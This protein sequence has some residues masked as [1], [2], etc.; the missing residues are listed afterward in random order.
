MTVDCL[1]RLYPY[2]E[3][4]RGKYKT[5]LGVIDGIPE[6]IFCNNID[7]DLWSPANYEKSGSSYPIGKMEIVLLSNPNCYMVIENNN[8]GMF[9]CFMDGYVKFTYGDPEKFAITTI[10]DRPG[11]YGDFVEIGYKVVKATQVTVPQKP[12]SISYRKQD[13]LIYTSGLRLQPEFDLTRCD[14]LSLGFK[15]YKDAALQKKHGIIYYDGGVEFS[16]I[17]DINNKKALALE[18]R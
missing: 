4:Q 8:L 11:F 2:G 16:T 5:T 1:Y 13:G 14:S 7:P 12:G 15:G 17:V 6:E 3:V 18:R 10:W 9:A